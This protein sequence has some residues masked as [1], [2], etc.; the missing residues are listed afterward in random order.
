M[1]GDEGAV[2]QEVEP[3]FELGWTLCTSPEEDV[4]PGLEDGGGEEGGGGGAAAGGTGGS[5]PM[6]PADE[7]LLCTNLTM[8]TTR[9]QA[10]QVRSRSAMPMVWNMNRMPVVSTIAGPIR[11]RV[12]QR[13]QPQL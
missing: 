12:L 2:E 5:G 9:I 10:G 13:P 4:A 1:S 3:G 11:Q 7:A 8:P 6:C